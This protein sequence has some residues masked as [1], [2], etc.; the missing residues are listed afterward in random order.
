MCP[1]K[2]ANHGDEGV[3]GPAR[4][5]VHKGKFNKR[6]LEVSLYKT[7]IYLPSEDPNGDVC[8]GH[9]GDPNLGALGALVLKTIDCPE[10]VSNRVSITIFFLYLVGPEAVHVHLLG[11]GL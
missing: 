10:S 5:V 8:D 6:K 4:V 3:R 9:L 11:L 2:L 7:C 1:A